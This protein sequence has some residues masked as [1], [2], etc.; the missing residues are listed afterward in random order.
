[1]AEKV[2]PTV[3]LIGDVIRPPKAAEM[4]AA[5]LRRQIVRGDLVEGD[6]LPPEGTLMQQFSV[7]RPTLREA[8]RVLEAESLITISRGARGGARV[9]TP[10][11]DGAARYA[12]LVLEYQGATLR[13]VFDAR[14]VIEPG[15]VALLALSRTN[16]DLALLR[17][18]AARASAAIND[19]VKLIREQ[20]EFHALLIELCG[21][22]TLRLLSD[23]LRH[24]VD[25][26]NWRTVDVDAGSTD[27]VR[28]NRKGHRAH[29][30]VIDLIE[31]K[32]DRGAAELWRKHLKEAEAYILRGP[33]SEQ[34]VLDLLE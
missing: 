13:D 12:G 5:S 25:R 1:M 11:G 3:A 19:P 33:L 15:C 2:A 20:T 31:A 34:T 30:R 24:I 8:F 17:E 14:L 27:N 32:D 10:N 22:Q 29:H 16:E 7:S 4:I 18:A 26:A 28:A 6:P 9:H 21:N 23:M